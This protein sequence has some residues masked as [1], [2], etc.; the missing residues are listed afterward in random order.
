M[1]R[2]LRRGFTLM[3]LLVVVAVI[4]VLIG[5]LLPAVQ[6]VRQT[7]VSKKLGSGAPQQEAAPPN[8]ADAPKDAV[9]PPAPRARARVTTFVAKVELTPKLSVGTATPESIYEAKFVGQLRAARPNEAAGECELELPLPPQ[10]I[11]LA[12]LSITADGVPSPA[13][14]LRDGKLV[15]RGKLDKP[16]AMEVTY[17][18][19]GKGL[20]ELSVP[21]G[22]SLD[23]FQI[24]LIANGSDVRLLE[25]SLQPTSLERTA[26]TTVYTWDYKQ[27]LFGQPV[28]LDVLGISPIDR[29]GELT[30]LGP[31]S[32]LIFGLLVGLVAQAFEV[33]K[34]DRWMLLLTVG[35]FAGAYPLMYFAQEFIPLGAAVVASAG[36]ALLIIGVRAVT[37]MGARL[38]LLGTVAPAAAILALTMLAAT[39][40]KLQGILLTA[41]AIGVF[42]VAMILFPKL[43]FAPVEPA[44]SVPSPAPSAAP[45]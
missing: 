27:L 3:E 7:A 14:S 18:A 23:H 20:Y 29:L 15:W 30:W 17:T 35:T 24:T 32:V 38:A 22:G 16:T 6:K 28:R 9:K 37:L 39:F 45:A 36:I 25:L 42:I 13:V 10:T 4:A 26:G 21:P 2:S 12:D 43:K 34:F 44:P 1:S 40:P 31:L 41:E 33:T 11:S 19:V 8:A 5:L